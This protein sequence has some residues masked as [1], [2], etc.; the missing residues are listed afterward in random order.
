MNHFIDPRRSVNFKQDKDKEIH[1]LVYQIQT[2]ENQRQTK[3]LKAVKGTKKELQKKNT[4]NDGYNFSSEV[5]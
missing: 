3:S 2:A 5:M 1:R 4:T